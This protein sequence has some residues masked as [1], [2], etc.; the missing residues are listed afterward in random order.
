M[1]DIDMTVTWQR[2][3]YED[4]KVVWK[5]GQTSVTLMALVDRADHIPFGEPD[6]EWMQVTPLGVPVS[7][8]VFLQYKTITLEEMDQFVRDEI[9]SV[10]PTEWGYVDA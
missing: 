2:D 7:D 1:V 9:L 4:Y 3:D 8:S 6:Y 5:Y 10:D